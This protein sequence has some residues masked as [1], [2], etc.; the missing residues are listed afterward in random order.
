MKVSGQR[1]FP[2]EAFENFHFENGDWY[3]VQQKHYACPFWFDDSTKKPRSEVPKENFSSSLDHDFTCSQLE[4]CTMKNFK[5]DIFTI[6]QHIKVDHFGESNCGPFKKDLTS[7]LIPSIWFNIGK[8]I[9]CAS[10]L[11]DNETFRYIP[12]KKN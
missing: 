10:K 6:W 3:Q 9:C 12:V 2:V 4:K 7:E 8:P 1:Q 5:T 11:K